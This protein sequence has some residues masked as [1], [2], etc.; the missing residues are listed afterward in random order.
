[1]VARRTV[2]RATTGTDGKQGGLWIVH[3]DGSDATVP[4]AHV[5]LQL[6][7]ARAGHDTTWSPDGKQIAFVSSSPGPETAA[8]TGDPVVITRY[9]YHADGERRLHALQ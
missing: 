8:A 2:A 7:A 6:A 4:R 5:R 9:L 1:M 3:P